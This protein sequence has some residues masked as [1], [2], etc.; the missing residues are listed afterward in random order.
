MKTKGREEFSWLKR[1]LWSFAESNIILDW[2]QGTNVTVILP[3][4]VCLSERSVNVKV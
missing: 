4:N 3:L 2:G 1:T